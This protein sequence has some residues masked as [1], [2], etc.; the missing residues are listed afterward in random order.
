VSVW[1]SAGF[2]SG[3]KNQ[4]EVVMKK[5]LGVVGALVA[6]VCLTGCLSGATPVVGLLLTSVKGP[7]TATGQGS[8]T[9][10]GKSPAI[11]I[12]GLV[13]FGDASIQSA[14]ANGGIKTVSHVDYE[15]LSILGAFSQYTTVVW[16][17]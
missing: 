13:A 11:S 2:L 3:A 12:L 4:G 14:K 16:G 1:E 9:K 17:D 7:I 8:G 15:A 5:K 6:S 10:S